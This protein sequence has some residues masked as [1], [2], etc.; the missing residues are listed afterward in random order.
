MAGTAFA[1]KYSRDTWRSILWFTAETFAND[2]HRHVN[3]GLLRHA[4]S[5]EGSKCEAVSASPGYAALTVDTLE[6]GDK[7]HTEENSRRDPRPAAFLVEWCTLL[8]DEGVKAG[9]CEN[10]IEIGVERV[11]GALGD[12]VSSNEEFPLP[13]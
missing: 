4:V 8:L 7:Q 11:P 1:R 10:L 3:R 9:G 12:A 2:G 6:I 13:L 5:E